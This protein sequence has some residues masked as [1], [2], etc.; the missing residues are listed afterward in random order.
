MSAL[1]T[2]CMTAIPQMIK[3]SWQFAFFEDGTQTRGETD[4]EGYTERFFVSSK[5]EIKVKLLF[6]NDDFL[7]ME[8]HYGR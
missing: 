8:G 3:M 1:L 6:A 5:H 4:E 2:G 7:S